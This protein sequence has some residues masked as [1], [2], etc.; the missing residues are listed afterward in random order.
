M[1][2]LAAA[3]ALVLVAALVPV[4]PV[5]TPAS[6]AKGELKACRKECQRR[7]KTCARLA[8]RERTAKVAACK[9]DDRRACRAAVRT[10]F[11]ASRQSCRTLRSTCRACCK[12]GGSGCAG[13]PPVF[14]GGFPVPGRGVL[15]GL[16][17]PPG[18][19]GAGFTWLA[20]G[21]GTL[22]I[23]PSRRTP[24]AAAAECAAFVLACF[25]P[26]VRNWAGCFDEAP[27]CPSDQ[28]LPGD[29]ELCCPAA[30]GA[31]YQELRQA[32]LDGPTAFTRAIWD[33]P[34]CIPGLPGRGPR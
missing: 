18:P 8:K 31:R 34:S 32:G 25:R 27:P 12:T 22:V 9:G 16:P 33:A 11:R 20:T 23:D 6:A 21:D 7:A 24:V 19:N 14:D 10:T 4:E 1:K 15:D 5:A 30:C 13:E 3:L 28:P 2:R 17:L 29:V 26:G